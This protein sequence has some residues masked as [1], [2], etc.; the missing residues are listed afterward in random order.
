MYGLFGKELSKNTRNRILSSIAMIAI[1]LGVI[2]LGKN[3]WIIASVIFGLSMMWEVEKIYVGSIRALVFPA[4][5]AICVAVYFYFGIN[6]YWYLTPFA[7]V[8]LGWVAAFGI[9][10][11]NFER[12]IALLWI[13]KLMVAAWILMAVPFIFVWLF[14]VIAAADTGAWFFGRLI[15]GDKLWPSISP[16]KTWS[17]Q[18]MGVV[19][20][21]IVGGLIGL[22]CHDLSFFF[23]ALIAVSVALLSQ[24]GDLTV[25]YLKRR[26]GIKDMSNLIPGHGGIL[27]RF[28]GWIYVLPIMAA[29]I[30]WL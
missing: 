27:D 18:I 13:F 25:S 23:Y 11:Y 16:K 4:I 22:I 9:R 5:S 19:S 29:I 28:D 3:A 8:I 10:K 24:Y 6:N 26:N 17:G 7:A 14:F 30:Y 21:A 12:A 20:A 15:G 2:L 1:A